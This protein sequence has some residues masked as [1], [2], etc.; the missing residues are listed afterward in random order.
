MTNQPGIDEALIQFLYR[1]PI[2]LL[3]TS[4]DGAIEM[5][6][7]MSAQLLMPLS[8]DG[9]LNNL[10]TILAGVAPELRVRADSYQDTSGVICEELR[11]TL[12]PGEAGNL[13]PVVLSISLLRLDETRL[14]AVVGDVTQQV[15]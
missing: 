4:L 6:N 9:T 5:L 1:A 12:A 8:P 13:A 14:M 7:P 3:Q 15:A 2:G 11:V 10:F